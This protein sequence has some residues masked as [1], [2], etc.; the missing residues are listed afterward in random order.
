MKKGV[1][2][3]PLFEE[4]LGHLVGTYSEVFVAEGAL[5]D[6]APVSVNELYTTFRGKEVL[7]KKGKA[8]RDALASEVARASTEWK[9]GHDIIYQKGG[10]AT[11]LI[12]LYFE[13]L[14][15]KSWEPG[16]LSE[17]GNPQNPYLKKDATNYIK[18]IE[19]AV[20][21]GCGIDDCNNI[22][23][24]VQKAEDKLRPRTQFLYIIHY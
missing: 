4:L 14:L 23:V 9:R 22:N 2:H 10:G 13:K 16:G 21:R 7:N 1:T 15:S 19:D 11:L 17:K 12:A 8:F 5:L 24:M 18:I 20:A 6:P 3:P